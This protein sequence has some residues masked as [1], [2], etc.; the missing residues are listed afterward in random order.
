[1]KRVASAIVPIIAIDRKA[2]EPLHRQIYDAYR[3]AILE[4]RLRPRERVPSTRTLATELGVSRMPVLNAYAQLLAEGYFESRVG[5]GTQI[6]SSLPDQHAA[7]DA[8]GA[9]TAPRLSGARPVS[10]RASR[11]ARAERPV[12]HG[13]GAFGVGQVA[14][15]H[16]PI[17][18]WSRLVTRHCRGMGAGTAHYGDQMGS[19]IFRETIAGYLRTARGVSCEAQQ[20]MIVS[21]SQYALEITARV[22]LDPGSA[23]WMEEPG[24]SFMRDVLSLTGCRIVP[25]PVDDEGLD[26]AAGT[27]LARK[28]RAAFVTP[29]HQY[30]LGVT[31]SAT[32]RLQLLAWAQS[33]GSWIIEDDY[34]SEFRYGSQPI[35][36]LQGLDSHARVIYIGTF[37]KVLFP[38]LRLGYIVMPPDLVERFHAVRRTMDLS[39]PSFY[40]DVVADFIREGHFARHIRRMRTLYRD[41][42]GALV[43]SIRDEFGTDV[44]I[45]GSEAGLHLAVLF[46]GLKSDIEF[47]VKVARHQ[48]WLRPLSPAYVGE[49]PRQGFILGFGSGSAEEIPRAIRKIRGVLLAK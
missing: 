21:G 3:S 4:R 8:R 5:T 39:P 38:S 22:L 12:W 34:D 11:M 17:Q 41:R 14:F 1:M 46:P 6:C 29:S 24:Y 36:S 40:Q 28:A 23:V 49:A 2:A 35:A 25:V 30:P 47:A 45:V 44:Q 16:F 20:I 48:V 10:L 13:F 42:R 27:R 31:M 33:A 37:S 15:E 19:G 43:E 26:V 32:R 9:A 7:H 18:I